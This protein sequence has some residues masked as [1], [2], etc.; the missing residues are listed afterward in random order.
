VGGMIEQLFER[1][2][3]R[4]RASRRASEQSSRSLRSSAHGRKAGRRR[5]GAEPTTG[6]DATSAAAMLAG[7]RR[8]TAGRTTLLVT[9]DPALLDAGD[10]V[11]EVFDRGMRACPGL[12]RAS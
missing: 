1:A 10:R 4:L 8:L 6:L 9:H 12:G 7:L 11:V 3:H 2:K 5:L